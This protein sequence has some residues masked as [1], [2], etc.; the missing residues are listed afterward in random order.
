[1][2]NL[3]YF[4][5]R[6]FTL[7]AWT[8][9]VPIML[10]GTA[11]PWHQALVWDVHTGHHAAGS[12]TL[13]SSCQLTLDASHRNV[14]GSS[15]LE[16]KRHSLFSSTLGR[17]TSACINQPSDFPTHFSTWNHEQTSL[18]RISAKLNKRKTS[19]RMCGWHWGSHLKWNINFN[20]SQWTRHWQFLP[21]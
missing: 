2:F 6:Y 20:T 21:D 11:W 8:P 5:R 18:R 15:G 16:K 9:R 12:S 17:F 19:K 13:P 3:R 1:M 7:C 10:S 14:V 4:L